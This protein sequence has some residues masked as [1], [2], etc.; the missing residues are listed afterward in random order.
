MPVVSFDLG[1]QGEAVRAANRQGA[2]ATVLP[3]EPCGGIDIDAL[4]TAI[5][6]D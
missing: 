6:P 3:F 1:A 4:L 2:Q 5:K